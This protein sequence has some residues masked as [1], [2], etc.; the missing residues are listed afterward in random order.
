ML[1][2]SPL[3]APTHHD[4][5]CHLEAWFVPNRLVWDGTSSGAGVTAGD[6][7]ED[8]ITGGE[9]GNNS[10]TLP[11]TASANDANWRIGSLA[12]HFDLPDL[13]VTGKHQQ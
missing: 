9:D 4:I 11:T 1:R 12:D 8:F 10:A 13:I 7:W 3:L 2:Q 5:G 6:N